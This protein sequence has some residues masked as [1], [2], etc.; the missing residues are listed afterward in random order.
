MD[1]VGDV[2]DPEIIIPG[3]IE[4]IIFASS[5]ELT[6]DPVPYRKNIYRG[7]YDGGAWKYNDVLVDTLTSEQSWFDSSIPG[8]GSLSY[9]L[10]TAFN[11][12]GEGP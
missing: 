9:Y 7:S 11:S 10:V 12:C 3:P 1:Q 8:A 2:C 5:E 6:W 4:P